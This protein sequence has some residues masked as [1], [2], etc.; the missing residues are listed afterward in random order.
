MSTQASSKTEKSRKGLQAARLVYPATK[1]YKKEMEEARKNNT[2]L[3]AWCGG[4]ITSIEL[5]YAFDILPQHIDNMGATFAAKQVSLPFIECSEADDFNRD[6]CSYYKT[7]YGYLQIGNEYPQIS[8]I[9]WPTPDLLVGSNAVCLTHSRGIRMLQN[10]F[11]VPAFVF[12]CLSPHTRMDQ[13]VHEENAPYEHSVIGT[14]YK[15]ELDRKYV[16]YMI[17]QQKGL[18]EFLEGVTGKKLDWGK[19]REVMELSRR[20]SQLFLELQE[21]RMAVPCPVGP[22]DIMSLVGPTFIWAGSDRG[23]SIFEEAVKEAKEKISRREGVIPEEKH[24]L[25]FEPIPPW[26]S[27]GLFNYLQDNY[28]AVSVIE[29]YPMEFTY[30]VDPL[31]PLESLAEKQLKYLYNYSPRERADLHIR[32]NKEYKVEGVMYWNIICCRIITMFAAY[33]KER[34]ERENNIPVIVLDADQADPRDYS[35]SVV[36]SRLD[37][38]M[39]MLRSRKEASGSQI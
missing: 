1:A 8:D 32:M 7:V 18:I 20:L 14:D 24:R 3:I 9:A 38:F 19:L 35:E 33:L 15:H 13:H 27:L 21:L 39:E 29:A 26:Y 12:D 30:M 25:F 22:V 16:D 17:A 37:A 34:V 11:S 36:K 31:N 6:M 10:Y 23:I 5:L 2:G 4:G 28:G